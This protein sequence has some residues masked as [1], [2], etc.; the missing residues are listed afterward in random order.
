MIIFFL[1]LPQSIFC[2]CI[3]PFFLFASTDLIVFVSFQN[4]INTMNLVDFV[5]VTQTLSATIAYECVFLCFLC[6]CNF[7]EV[8]LT[9]T[10]NFFKSILFNAIVNLRWKIPQHSFYVISKNILV[11]SIFKF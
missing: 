5:F 1:S 3:Y 2:T 4:W 6:L 11:S 7:G 10:Q 9:C 8:K